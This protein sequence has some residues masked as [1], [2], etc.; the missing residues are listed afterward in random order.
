MAEPWRIRTAGPD[1]A[2]AF[3]KIHHAAVQ[4]A[5]EPD[6]VRRAWSPSPDDPEALAR[7]RD[8]L[9][10]AGLFALLAEDPGGRPAGF[11][12]LDR[13]RA[14]VQALYIHPAHARQ[15]LGSRL[16]HRLLEEARASGLC[17]LHV[18]SSRQAAPLY[19]RHGFRR[20]TEGRLPIRDT[21][22]E[23]PFVAMARDLRD[24]P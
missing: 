3:R 23:I 24:L 10:R 21:G 4:A 9:S 7:C 6:E 19:A 12:M 20:Q 8:D 22:V 16:L 11:A 15:G 18:E 1:D 13:T 14:H 2:P 17:N 5:P